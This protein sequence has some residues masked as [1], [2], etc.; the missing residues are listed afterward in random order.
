MKIHKLTHALLILVFA[1]S[2][3]AFE[4]YQQSPR[5]QARLNEYLKQQQD[6]RLR[7]PIAD[8]EE[9]DLADPKKNE[10]RMEKRLRKNDVKL[11]A[12]NPRYWQVETVLINEGGMDFQHFR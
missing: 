4:R 1:T 10:A 5:D 2:A 11:V 7:F 8:Y 6:R 12:R 9:K 3:L